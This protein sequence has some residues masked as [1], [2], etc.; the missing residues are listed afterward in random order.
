MS[1]PT[2]V[3]VR[4][5]RR[6]TWSWET[7]FSASWPPRSAGC[8]GP[9][10][11]TPA[12]SLT[13]PAGWWRPSPTPA[14]RPCPRRC[15]T[16]RRPRRWRWPATAGTCSG[17]HGFTRSDA[18]V[19]VGGGAT[20]DLAGFVAATW[21]R[22]VRVVLVP[23]TLLRHGRRGRRRQDRRSTP[24]RARTWSARSTRRPASLCD[25]DAA[26]RRCPP[27][28]YVSGPGRGGQGRLHRRPAR[29]SSWS[30]PTRSAAADAG[31]RVLRELVERAVAGQGGG[32]R[33]RTCAEAGPAGDPQLRPHARATRSRRSSGT[34]GGTARRSASAW[35]SPPSWPRWP[36]GSTTPPRT[37]TGR[38]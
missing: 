36:A 3:R 38:C 28:D 31:D 26:R 17:R 30:R 27:H 16:A 34:A 22:G 14:S 15:P 35:C 37:G 19:G 8:S 25:L 33:R 9:R 11:C 32:G 13:W 29:S 6:T 10:W 23:T 18:V 5:P 1:A 2:R 21:L 7:T 20:T 4:A 12:G 24:P